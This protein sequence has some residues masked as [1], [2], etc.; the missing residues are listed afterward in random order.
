MAV[1]E[2]VMESE[3]EGEGEEGMKEEGEEKPHVTYLVSWSVPLHVH[4]LIH[5]PHTHTRRVKAQ[6]SYV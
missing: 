4:S 3:E 1:P 2:A 5:T 6:L